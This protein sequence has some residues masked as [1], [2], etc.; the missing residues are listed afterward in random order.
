MLREYPWTA[1]SKLYVNLQ[2]MNWGEKA[3][4]D[5]KGEI[6]FARLVKRSGEAVEIDDYETEEYA[7]GRRLIWKNSV[8]TGSFLVIDK[9]LSI[10]S[11]CV[12]RGK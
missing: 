7:E 3:E 6:V 9:A 2:E 1:C 10:T 4:F 5:L 12:P 8:G 11:L